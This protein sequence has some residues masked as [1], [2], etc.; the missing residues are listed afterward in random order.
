M[1]EIYR[2]YPW[3]APVRS[4]AGVS[5]FYYDFASADAW[6]AA[7]RVV[8]VLGEVPEFTP[9]ALSGLA[10]GEVGPFRCAEEV[11][12]H[13]EDVRRRA[14]AYEVLGLKR[15]AEYPENSE[16]ALLAATY[17]KQAGKV[18]AFSLAVFRQVFCAGRSLAD[19]ETVFLA[20]AAAEM[21]PA[22]LRKGAA[23][24]GTAER[25]SAATEAAVASGVLDVPAVVIG[26]RVFHGDLQLP[27]AAEALS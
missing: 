19:Q 12:A 13:F 18:V 24:R 22:A 21:H 26:D 16:F 2:G 1:G 8:R 20:G 27:L 6:L 9:V 14:E 5:V 23:L 11:D 7:E 15:P 3:P 10:A 4:L 17:A 25:L